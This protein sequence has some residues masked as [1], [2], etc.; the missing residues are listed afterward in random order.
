MS[1]VICMKSLSVRLFFCFLTFSLCLQAQAVALD[2]EAEGLK[3]SQERKARDSGWVD[4]EGNTTMVLR[5]ARGQESRRE[6]QIKVKEVDGDGDKSLTIFKLPLD[7]KGTAL[8]SISHI[9]G[10]DDQWIYV[11]ALK[12]VK[13]IA[14]SNKSSAFMGSEFS[15]EDLSSFEV[16]KYTYRLLKEE[17]YDDALC[18]VVES[19]AKYDFSG[20]SRRISWV[21]KEHYRLRKMEFYDAKNALLK[22]LTTDDYRLYLG[23]YWRAHKL[24]MVN[25]LSGKSTD[26]LVSDMKFGLGFGDQEFDSVT[27]DRIR[28]N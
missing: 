7:I 28:V 8:L 12:R 26:L 19:I 1:M 3:I 25:N 5:S 24:V 23:K 14:S 27:L 11:P 18:F 20:Y 21:D 4:Y 15:Y 17:S 22:T 10:D 16:E 6:M 9:E 2:P 13:R